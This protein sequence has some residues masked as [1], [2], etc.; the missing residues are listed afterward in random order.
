MADADYELKSPP[1]DGI[2]S[3][4][5]GPSEVSNSLLVTS[6][7]GSA[8]LYDVKDNILEE[9]LSTGAPLLDGCWGQP[10]QVWVGGLS[11]KVLGIQ[12][13]ST[14]PLQELGQH[15]APIKS[16]L[17]DREDTGL[18]ISG[19]W[20]RMVKI[21]DPRSP[22]PL[23]HSL[24]QPDKV[25][26][27]DLTSLPST[28]N[29]RSGPPFAF[30]SHPGKLVVATA[31]RWIQVYDLRK[32]PLPVQQRD[33]CLKYQTRCIRCSPTWDGFLLSSI[34]GR[35]AVEYFA[36]DPSI[37]SKRYAFKCHR[38]MSSDPLNPVE[39]VYP[40][41]SLAFHPKTGAFVTGGS[42]GVICSWDGLVRKRI[43]SFPQYPTSI[44]SL[45]FNADGS[46]L[47]IAVSYQYEEGERDH[48][49]DA[50][51]IKRIQEVDMVLRPQ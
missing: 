26:S 40:V 2:S 4:H 47:A 23:V 6:W 28:A 18:L 19:G 24:E 34:E 37:Q 5:F 33:S 38:L 1:K 12:F 8:R 35:A 20:D 13:S 10:G 31:G 3:V 42:D 43:R 44:S 50:I 49:L 36:D 16:I 48:P 29:L 41:N 7:D 25:Y 14:S 11:G 22:T 27:M 45:D 39:T 30:G 17:F 32:L 21:W 51:H 46:L 15:D 9:Q